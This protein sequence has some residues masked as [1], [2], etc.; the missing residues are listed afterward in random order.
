MWLD[1]HFDEE[2]TISQKVFELEAPHFTYII[3]HPRR[4]FCEILEVLSLVE[5]EI[6][7]LS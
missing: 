1:H 6:M 7:P 3:I 2:C 5:P 4:S